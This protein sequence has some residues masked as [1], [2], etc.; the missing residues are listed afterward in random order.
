MSRLRLGNADLTFTIHMPIIV[1][2]AECF[3]CGR[4]LGPQDQRFRRSVDV[5]TTQSVR[6]GRRVTFGTSH[7][8]GPRTVCADC[9]RNIDRS[10]GIAALA[11]GLVVAVGGVA[12]CVSS[13]SDKAQTSS[14]VPLVSQEVTT[15]PDPLDVLPAKM[16]DLDIRSAWRVTAGPTNYVT[17]VY[18]WPE[19]TAE[20]R[21]NCTIP[22]EDS[23][24]CDA[25]FPLHFRLAGIKACGSAQDDKSSQTGPIVMWPGCTLQVLR[26]HQQI[27]HRFERMKAAATAAIPWTQKMRTASDYDLSLSDIRRNRDA[28]L[29]AATRRGNEQDP[30]LSNQLEA[31]HPAQ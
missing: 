20:T 29:L 22:H 31:I 6:F 16:G 13:V 14:H 12:V 30:A 15:T 27:P 18:S 4:V 25:G 3:T 17:G 10:S 8:S 24:D 19:G 28:G 7:R 1:A 11:V 23:A 9:A 5:G 26:A 21:L 2:V